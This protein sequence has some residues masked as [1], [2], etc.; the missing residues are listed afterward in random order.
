MPDH[1]PRD[2][3]DSAPA[4]P[5]APE[6]LIAALPLSV[7][8]ADRVQLHRLAARLRAAERDLERGGIA[9]ALIDTQRTVLDRV[10]R[11]LA[12][13]RDALALRTDERDAA[14]EAWDAVRP[15]SDPPATDDASGEHAVPGTDDSERAAG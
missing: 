2:L 15:K 8:D 4:V 3:D 1:P 6:R 5:V 7:G 10:R 11:E 9:H 13:T 12:E 14:Q